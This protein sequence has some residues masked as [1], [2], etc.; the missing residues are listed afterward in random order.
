MRESLK[1]ELR[2]AYHGPETCDQ[3]TTRLHVSDRTVRRFW[4]AERDANQLPP[5]RP[6]FRVLPAY[7]DGVD[8]E[9]D[10]AL[11]RETDALDDDAPMSSPHGLRI[12]DPDAL[13]IALDREHSRQF[14]RGRSD[15]VPAH[16]LQMEITTPPSAAR[17]RES[18]RARDAHVAGKI[19][20]LAFAG[21]LAG[22]FWI[23]SHAVLK[24]GP[25]DTLA[26]AQRIARSTGLIGEIGA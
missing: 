9:L 11:A 14:I 17:V 12:A 5:E 1:R 10:A 25:F 2:V 15:E 18:A 23:I 22:G 19:K 21:P 4:A 20:P 7:L 8:S 6:R 24:A 26:A 13:L 16:T 3:I